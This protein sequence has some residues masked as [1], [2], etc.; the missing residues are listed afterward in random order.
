MIE[1]NEIIRLIKEAIPDAEVE[2][3][4]PDNKHYRAIVKSSSFK[5]KSLIE[6]HQLVLKPLK[7]ALK[8]ELHAISIKTIIPE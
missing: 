8:E 5:D 2:V 6:Q 7:E 4:S 1:H 3:I